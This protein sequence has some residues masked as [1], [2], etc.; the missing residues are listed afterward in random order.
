[1][2]SERDYMVLHTWFS[3]AYLD[4]LETISSFVFLYYAIEN[5]VFP[6]FFPCIIQEYH[7]A[8]STLV[9]GT[10]LFCSFLTSWAFLTCD[11]S[12]TSVL[13]TVWK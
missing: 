12:H 5:K 9:F 7:H 4:D 2:S 6:L 1:M 11:P 3:Y 10:F 8:S 13:M